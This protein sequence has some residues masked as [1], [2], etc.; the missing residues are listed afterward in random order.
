MWLKRV[1]ARAQY[2]ALATLLPTAAEPA[3]TTHL[4][5]NQLSNFFTIA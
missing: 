3:E 2:A 5:L 1:D 4:Q